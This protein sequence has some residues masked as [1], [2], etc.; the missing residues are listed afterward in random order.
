MQLKILSTLVLQR[1]WN[2]E[3]LFAHNTALGESEAQRHISAPWVL[4]RGN[5]VGML[6]LSKP[7]HISA[8][9]RAPPVHRYQTGHHCLQDSLSRH[10]EFRRSR[11]GLQWLDCTSRGKNDCQLVGRCSHL[12]RIAEFSKY[13]YESDLLVGGTQ[14]F[15]ILVQKGKSQRL[16]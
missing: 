16:V 4:A 7:E 10:E 9:V 8:G 12:R 13:H 3:I 1:T 5:S 14:V 11:L 2:S 6:H 15:F